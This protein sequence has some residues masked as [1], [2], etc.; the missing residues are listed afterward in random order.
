MPVMHVPQR[1]QGFTLVEL[2]IVLVII[3]VLAGSF[4]GTFGSRIDATRNA[5]TKE[6]LENIKK[7]II[8]FALSSGGP[9][10]PC[11]DIDGDGLEDRTGSLCDSG[12]AV[13]SLPWATLGVPSSDAWNTRYRY[14]VDRNFADDGS[15]S[16]STFNLGDNAIGNVMTR[17]PGGGAWQLAATN[18]VAVIY[19]HGRNS[20]GGRDIRGIARAAIPVANVDESENTDANAIFFS[21]EPTAAGA[22]SAGGEFDD[23][24]IWISEF[25]LKATMAETGMLP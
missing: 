4:L 21:R 24:V 5:N 23:I 1:Q 16:G 14:W 20:Y 18:V 10:L 15:V 17:S 22:A 19:S 11:S 12:N 7:A 25:E 13:G 2:A 8:G 6:D 3:G 9:F